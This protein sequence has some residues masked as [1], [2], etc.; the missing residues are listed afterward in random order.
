MSAHTPVIV[1]LISGRGS[2]MDAIL[3]SRVPARVAAVISNRPGAAGL[4]SASAAGIATEVIDHRAYAAREDFDAALA[5]AIARHA[6]DWIVLAGFMRVL[7]PRFLERFANRVVN[8]HPSLLPAFPGLHTHRQALEAGVRLHGATV[9]V[10]TPALDHGPILAQAAVPVL[11]GDTEDSLAARVL[12]QE[13]RIYPATLRALL[14]GRITLEAGGVVRFQSPGVE[15]GG[16]ALINP[17]E[18]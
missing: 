11:P 2:N 17:E 16:K 9:H 4:A 3:R 10:V 15:Q 13:H 5:D 6:P 7:T 8:I 12:V 1:I 14:E 18:P